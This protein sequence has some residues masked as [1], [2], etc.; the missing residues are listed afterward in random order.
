MSKIKFSE[1]L[2]LVFLTDISLYSLNENVKIYLN[3]CVAETQTY[4]YIFECSS[5]I[6]LYLTKGKLKR[7]RDISMNE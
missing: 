5:C 6:F 7:F 4:I 2:N 3:L 1:F